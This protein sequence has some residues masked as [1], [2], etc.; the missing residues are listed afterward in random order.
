MF[1]T[2]H[3]VTGGIY[4]EDITRRREDM[5]FYLRV[6]KTIFYEQAQRE[7]K[8]LF[9]G[10]EDES[11]ILKPPCNVL[12]IISSQAKNCINTKSHMIDIFTSKDMENMSLCVSRSVSHS[13]LYNNN[14]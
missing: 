14:I 6:V 4:K 7:S 3:D 12:F 9:L 13:L 8:I 1:S 10:L 5:T 2:V 11:H